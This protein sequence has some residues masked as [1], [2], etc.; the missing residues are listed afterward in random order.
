MITIGLPHFSHAMPVSG[1]LTGVPA[2]STSDM[3][4]HFA[5]GQPAYFFPALLSFNS[6]LCFS[7]FGHL[8]AVGS[9]VT[10]RFPSAV[11]FIVV[12]QSG[13]PSHV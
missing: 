1:G 8:N 2:A 7:H 13:A 10:V 11:S 5:S 6:R 4:P 3:Y 12:G 9:A